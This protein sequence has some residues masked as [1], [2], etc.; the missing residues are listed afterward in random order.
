MDVG[1]VGI[2]VGV[3]GIAIAVVALVKSKN[4]FIIVNYQNHF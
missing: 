2:G 3:I 1:Y 4:N